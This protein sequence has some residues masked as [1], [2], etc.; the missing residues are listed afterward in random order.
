VSAREPV[1]VEL[2]VDEFHAAA[3]RALATV[4][5]TYAELAAQAAR[6]QFA[7]DQARKVWSCI[8]DTLPVE[9]T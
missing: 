9:F 5:L 4:G 2:T 8:G 6:H 1:V 3:R 7:S